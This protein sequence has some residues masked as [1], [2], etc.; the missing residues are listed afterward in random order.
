MERSGIV[1]AEWLVPSR[2]T[3]RPVGRSAPGPPYV[4][5]P[6]R[7]VCVASSP[8]LCESDELAFTPAWSDGESDRV[9]V[10]ALLV[11]IVALLPK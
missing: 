1:A 8:V 2:L 9:E 11:P 7:T 4:A 10:R 6:S 5:L 3:S